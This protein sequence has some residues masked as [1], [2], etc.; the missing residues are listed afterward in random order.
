MGS[1]DTKV[2]IVGGGVA[3]LEA[4][5]ALRGIAR[6]RLTLELITPRATWSYRPMAVAEP[7]GLGEAKTYD[8]VKLARDHGATLHVAGVHSID[9]RSHRLSTWGRPQS[10]LRDRSG[11]RGC[12]AGRGDPWQRDGNGSRLHE[13][14]PNRAARPGRTQNPPGRLRRACRGVLAIAPL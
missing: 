3:A 7:F 13:P 10:L 12:A 4:L 6:E 11:R 9:S 5:I 8:L 2:T 14:L 1:G